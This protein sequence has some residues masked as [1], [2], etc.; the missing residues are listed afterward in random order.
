LEIILLLIGSLLIVVGALIIFSE[1]QA[2]RGTQPVRGRV[3]G[4]SSGRSNLSSFSFHTVAEFIGPDGRTYYAEGSV[5]SS[6]PLHAV[7]APVTVLVRPMEPDK[8]VLKSSLSFVLGGALAL[9][10]MV[11]ALLFW[12]TFE[13]SIFSVVIATA[14]AGGF[15]LKVKNAWRKVPLSLQAWQEYKKQTLSPRVFRSKE[16][17][18]WADPIRVAVAVES[19]KKSNRASVPILLSIGFGLFFA[20]HYAYKKTET[21][22]RQADRTSGEVVD[23]VVTDPSDASSTT[24]A[25]VVEYRDPHSQNHRL[26]DSFSSSPPWYHRGQKV[27]IL[28]S[29][30]N[31]GD[32]Q[33]DRGRL[34]H[35]FTIL[36]GSFGGLFTAFGLFGARRRLRRL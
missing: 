28:Y 7:G 35:W 23:L 3:I 13:A 26:V 16:E 11:C 36:L 18:Q 30:D 6:V 34:N 1:V 32:A 5:G 31:P 29:R 25:A 8:A 24:Y 2:R 15:A 33:I 27:S 14:V 9:M 20:S 4:F 12:V 22:L 19:Y 10:G 17:I 21:F